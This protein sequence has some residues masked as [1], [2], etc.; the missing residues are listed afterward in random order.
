MTAVDV[1]VV[2]VVLVL[3]ALGWGRG[4]VAAALPL[5]GFVAGVAVGARLAP[6]LLEQGAE[7]P[8][9]PAVAALGGVLLGLLLAVL[10]GGLGNGLSRRLASFRL[11][12]LINNAGGAL[13]FAA[14]GLLAAW[15]FGAVALH[16]PG[17]GNR[18]LRRAIQR[19]V[20]LGELNERFPPSGEFLNVLRRVNPTPIVRGPDA[21]VAAPN[22]AVARDPEVR[23]AA[24]SVVRVRGTACGL[25]VEGSGWVAAPELIVTNAHVVAGQKDTVVVAGDGSEYEVRVL[26]YVP[27]NDL[28]VLRAPGLQAAPLPLVSRPRRGTPGAVIGYPAGGPLT[29]RPARLGRTGKVASQDSYGRGPVLRAMTPF[30]GDVRGGNSGGPVVD[31][32]GRVLTTVFAASTEAGSRAGLGVPNRIVRRVLSGPLDG[33]DTGPCA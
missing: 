22:P 6:K 21:D 26:A 7:S 2:A 27:R 8:Y 13:L 24:A 3:A 28:A 18:D 33:D 32:E 12:R 31:R 9:A 17:E 20:I 11:G 19:S 14:L 30:R 29:V 5:G 4:L 15:V 1:V 16:L 23:A 10:L 25:G